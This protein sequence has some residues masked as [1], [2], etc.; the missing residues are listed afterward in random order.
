M[1]LT[2][3][4]LIELVLVLALYATRVQIHKT[5]EREKRKMNIEEQEA[6]FNDMD[7]IEDR[8]SNVGLELPTYITAEFLDL[9]ELLEEANGK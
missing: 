8:A 3:F 6:Y 4:I 1:S 2:T 7:N 5:I 9:L